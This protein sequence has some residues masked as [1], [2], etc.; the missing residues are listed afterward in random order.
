[1]KIHNKDWTIHKPPGPNSK[2]ISVLFKSKSQSY[3]VSQYWASL[4]TSLTS[5]ESPSQDLD[6][7]WKSKPTFQNFSSESFEFRKI[8]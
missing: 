2:S 4:N 6:N 5:L 7:T 3:F 8:L 1:M